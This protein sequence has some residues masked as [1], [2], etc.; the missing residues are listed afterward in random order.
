MVPRPKS[1]WV[2]KL[3]L[4]ILIHPLQSWS[5]IDIVLQLACAAL[6][7]DHP[8]FVVAIT[9]VIT[10]IVTSS[11]TSALNGNCQRSMVRN[12]S[13]IHGNSS[14]IG[15]IERTCYEYVPRSGLQAGR[16]K[17]TWILETAVL[18]IHVNRSVHSLASVHSSA[19]EHS[20]LITCIH[21]KIRT[22]AWDVHSKT[23]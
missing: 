12:L 3:S 16:L 13:A 23:P 20:S 8:P 1:S 19:A 10:T 14:R 2:R 5:R 9:A 7:P 21:I 18:S 6:P 22:H 15:T 11:A 4:G 17:S